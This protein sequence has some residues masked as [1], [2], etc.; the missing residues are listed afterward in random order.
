M[1]DVRG[2][3]WHIVY[4]QTQSS[5]LFTLTVTAIE[6]AGKMYLTIIQKEETMTTKQMSL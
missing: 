5:G 1:K 4:C 2:W 6:A 3:K